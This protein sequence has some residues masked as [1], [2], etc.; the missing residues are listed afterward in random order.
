MIAGCSGLDLDCLFSAVLQWKGQLCPL[1]FMGGAVSRW[2]SDSTKAGFEE[3]VVGRGAA[4]TLLLKKR[5][6]V[7]ISVVLWLGGWWAN[8]E[9]WTALVCCEQPE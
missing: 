5:S 8:S 3:A 2:N 4:A 7:V 6:V 9:D 1:M